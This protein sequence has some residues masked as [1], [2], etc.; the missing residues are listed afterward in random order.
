MPEGITKWTKNSVVS[1][2]SPV[3]TPFRFWGCRVSNFSPAVA[4]CFVLCISKV[5]YYRS[6]AA[7]SSPEAKG[8]TSLQAKCMILLQYPPSA[9]LELPGT[10]AVYFLVEAYY[11]SALLLQDVILHNAQCLGHLHFPA[12]LIKSTQGDLP[13]QLRL[14]QNVTASSCAEQLVQCSK[15]K[16]CLSG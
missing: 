14:S 5:G 7:V 16:C 10:G 3:V 4:L 11:V 12:V 9:C 13:N 15:T 1:F 6:A 2:L 8:I